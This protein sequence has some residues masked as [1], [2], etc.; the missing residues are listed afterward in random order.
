MSVKAPALVGYSTA[1]SV[2]SLGLFAEL[3]GEVLASYLFGITDRGELRDA[4][5]AGISGTVA[6]IRLIANDRSL[7]LGV[8]CDRDQERGDRRR[9]AAPRRP[10]TGDR[11]TTP[12]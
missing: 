11:S 4:T 1:C 9:S 10:C 7:R 6:V 12:S 8:G 2:R 5:T 3:P